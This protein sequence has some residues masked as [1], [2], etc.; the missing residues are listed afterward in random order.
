MVSTYCLAQYNNCSSPDYVINGTNYWLRMGGQDTSR[1]LNL[2]SPVPACTTPA[3]NLYG[4]Y[5]ASTT[6]V[7]G[8]VQV[9][10]GGTSNLTWNSSNVNSC[11]LSGTNG[12][13]VANAISVTSHATPAILSSTTYTLNCIGLDGTTHI[14]D[15]LTVTMVPKPTVVLESP[16]SGGTASGSIQVKGY[17][18]PSNLSSIKK[19][20]FWASSTPAEVASSDAGDANGKYLA[21][22]FPNSRTDLSSQ[23]GP[24][25]SSPSNAYSNLGFNYPSYNTNLLSNGSH[26]III[27]AYDTAGNIA[28]LNTPITVNNAVIC[29]PGGCGGL[30]YYFCSNNSCDYASGTVA[31][32]CSSC[33]GGNPGGGGNPVAA[34]CTSPAQMNITWQPGTGATGY[35]IWR[36]T[37]NTFSGA[38]KIATVAGN[39]TPLAYT[40]TG[41][42]ASTNY[43]Y[44]VEDS[45][46]PGTYTQAN[47]SASVTTN[48]CLSGPG[49][50]TLDNTTHCQEVDLSWPGVSN[51]TGYNVYRSAAN[52]FPG[53]SG[54]INGSAVAGL[55][56]QDKTAVSG[57]TYYY[58]VTGI[59]GGVNTLPT[60]GSGGSVGVSACVAQM[61]QSDKVVTQINNTPVAGAP[62]LGSCG[63][64]TI[65]LPSNTTLSLGDKLSFRI[66]LC[67]TANTSY[68]NATGILVKDTFTN[69][70][71]PGTGFNAKL[72]GTP[73]NYAGACAGANPPGAN[74]Q[75]CVYGTVP[76]QTLLFNLTGLTLGFGPSPSPSAYAALTFDAALAVSAN[77]GGT[78]SRFY[79]TYY[80]T[81]SGAINPT[82]TISWPFYTGNQ[83]P[84]IR[85]VP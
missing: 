49:S 78:S 41:V 77:T 84:V 54:K 81:N 4:T 72:N 29:A 9:P 7:H 65:N 50:V 46:A 6:P 24:S 23:Y 10:Y 3:A 40:D 12:D 53:S 38:V 85:E 31:S 13:S 66:D 75:Y 1:C 56:Y 48:S 59:V 51:A 82:G 64:S 30:S 2:Q 43:Y 16:V 17:A 71:V 8:T 83:V 47:A 14:T 67:N 33:G 21:G 63:H 58:W 32:D 74:N 37:A 20:E 69:L 45:N 36:N 68:A 60:P 57:S 15:T 35:N 79:N 61:S 52:T 62:V 27:V 80:I 26:T 22:F 19:I 70:A 55:S 34:Y 39:P 44:W 73:L 18:V 5:Y 42:T 11:S 25:G 76:N 28:I